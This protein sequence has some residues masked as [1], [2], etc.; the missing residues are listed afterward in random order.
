MNSKKTLVI[1]AT[2]RTDTYA[3]MAVRMLRSKN[4]PVVALGIRPGRIEDVDIDTARKK[5]RDI[6]TVTLYIGPDKLKDYFEYI[7]SLKPVRVIFNPGTE[8][9]EFK[10]ILEK[11]GIEAHYACTLVL[12]QTNQ[13]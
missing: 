8:S 7:R 5:Y 1:G 12:L 6:N 9:N 3:N 2:E 13:Y 10:E 4:V 11:Q